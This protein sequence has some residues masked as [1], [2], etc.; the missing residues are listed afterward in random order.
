MQKTIQNL[1]KAFV[2]E[3]QARN[4]YSF[5]AKIAQKEGYEQIAE[6]FLLTAEQEKS[7]AK[8]LFEEIQRLKKK[9]KENLDE[10]KIETVAPTIYSNT[11]NNLKAAIAGENH[12]Y[13][14]MYPE[15][16]KTAK[17][18]GLLKIAARLKAIAVA[19]K[20]HEERYKKLLKEIENKSVFKKKKA[21]WWACRECGYVHFGKSPPAECPSCDHAQGFYQIKC[22]KY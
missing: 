21:V 19:E 3:S 18:E 15:F 13:T 7:H 20:H 6:V 9:S 4:R 22:E 10:I 1:S 2:G 16:A 17:K 8:R 14:Q 11:K 12:E 5:Y